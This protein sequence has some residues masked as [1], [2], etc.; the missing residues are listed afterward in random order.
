VSSV[1]DLATL[2]VGALYARQRTK[3]CS[4]RIV[5]RFC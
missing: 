2:K 4:V 1:S 3:Y 5:R